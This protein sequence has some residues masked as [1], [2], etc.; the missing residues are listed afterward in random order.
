MYKKVIFKFFKLF[1]TSTV[2]LFFTGCPD[3][4]NSSG[5]KSTESQSGISIITENGY[6]ALGI[7]GTLQLTAEITAADAANQPVSWSSSNTSIATVNTNGVVSG[8]GTPGSIDITVSINDGS[9]TDTVT[10][11]VIEI[12][13]ESQEITIEEFDTFLFPSFRLEPA[14]AANTELSI[15]SSNP[16][17]L[18]IKNIYPIIDNYDEDGIVQ[19]IYL[20]EMKGVQLGTVNITAESA[21]NSNISSSFNMVV[22]EDKTNPKA[23]MMFFLNSHTVYLS[24][25]DTMN[26]TDISD[27]ANYTILDTTNDKTLQISSAVAQTETFTDLVL[28]TVLEELSIGNTYSITATSVKD[29][30]GNA[31]DTNNNTASSLYVQPPKPI[32]TDKLTEYGGKINSHA[33]AVTIKDNYYDYLVLISEADNSLFFFN[34][35]ATG[36]VDD[37][38]SI[39]GFIDSD[40]FCDVVFDNGTYEIYVVANYDSNDDNIGDIITISAPVTYE[41]TT[42]N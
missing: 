7:N 24:F 31:I 1:L 6:T 23:D 37:N 21:A 9:Y 26:K 22:E 10:I 16:S 29:E 2:I 4:L 20:V 35:T 40:M 11:D 28:I 13:Q 18:E 17:I 19:I 3:M 5:Q 41:V 33:G 38:G 30:A 42:G 39:I 15:T 27:L 12:V 32:D 25:N 8:V 36:Y 14:T 34:Y